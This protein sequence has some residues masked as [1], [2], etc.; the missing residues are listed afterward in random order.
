MFLITF[1]TMVRK[2]STSAF[3]VEPG[4]HLM[5]DERALVRDHFFVFEKVLDPPKNMNR[6]LVGYL[7]VF[8]LNVDGETDFLKML[9][10]AR[11]IRRTRSLDLAR[12]LN[13]VQIVMGMT[14]NGPL[15]QQN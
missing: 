7:F 2:V 1:H 4:I 5:D 6:L 15:Q 13:L 14:T 11:V 9:I 3:A 8:V 10:I 12:S